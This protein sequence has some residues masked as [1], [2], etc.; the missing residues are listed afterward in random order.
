MMLSVFSHV[1]LHFHIFSKNDLNPLPILNPLIVELSEFFKVLDMSPLSDIWCL[2]SSFLWVVF[3]T[4]LTLS[5]AH[6]FLILMKSSLMK[7]NLMN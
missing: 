6:K 1:Y 2:F 3:L 4:F 7:S 5:S